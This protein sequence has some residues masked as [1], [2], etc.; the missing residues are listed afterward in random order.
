MVQPS[1]AVAMV[2]RKSDD[3]MSLAFPWITAL[4]QAVIK[5]AAMPGAV[6]IRHRGLDDG[7]ILPDARRPDAPDGASGIYNLEIEVNCYTLSE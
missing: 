7:R 4:F 5:P 3:G 1:G 6:S 2:A